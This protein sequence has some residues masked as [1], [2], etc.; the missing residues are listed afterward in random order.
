MNAVWLF[1]LDAD[2]ELAAPE[3]Y[4]TSDRMA[5]RIE[6]LLSKL[7]GFPREGEEIAPLRGAR[8]G[9]EGRPARVWCPT[10]SALERG[11]ELG[12]ILDPVPSLSSL[13]LANRRQ[14]ESHCRRRLVTFDSRTHVS[15]FELP[16]DFEITTSPERNDVARPRLV[17][18]G[19]EH[20]DPRR[21]FEEGRA[22]GPVGPWVLKRDF[23]F[24]GLGL[25]VVRGVLSDADQSWLSL[26]L[27]VGPGRVQPWRE[28]LVD[29]V[30]HGWVDRPTGPVNAPDAGRVLLAPALVQQCGPG[31][32]WQRTRS[33]GPEEI[34]VDVARSLRLAAEL[35][36]E[37]LGSV[38]Y[39]G[40][41]GID[42]FVWR[43]DDRREHL[44]VCDVNARY[45][46]SWW[47]SRDLLEPDPSR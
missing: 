3:G 2:D 18:P 25:R 26:A 6:K 36:G 43:D 27:K 20:R 1:N 42:G 16:G 5:G 8:P 10:P 24:A 44:Y 34:S 17:S 40:P 13:R 11:R 7:Q 22:G 29:V 14:F 19:S 15:P 31:G 39:H 30:M 32:T 9:L 46:M 38:D 12:L 41:F 45:T 23:G 28:R 47:M 37:A 35:V 33:P 4:R 21:Q